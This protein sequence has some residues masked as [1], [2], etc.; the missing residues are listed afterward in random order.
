MQKKTTKG[1]M[2]N[3]FSPG[4]D[5]DNFSDDNTRHHFRVGTTYMVWERA[6]IHLGIN[7]A[8]TSADNERNAYW[9][10][11][12]QNRANAEIGIS[13]RRLGTIYSLRLRGGVGR[14]EV[15]LEEQTEYEDALATAIRNNTSLPEKLTEALWL[16]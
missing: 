7:Y 13:G 15:R 11:Y 16:H 10:P 2:D 8:Y 4:F 14:E 5:Y 1:K 6:G 12:K 3:Y 9:T